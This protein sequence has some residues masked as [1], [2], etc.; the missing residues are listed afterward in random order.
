PPS[1]AAPAR[2]RRKPAVRAARPPP[3]SPESPTDHAATAMRVCSSSEIINRC[4]RL[5]ARQHDSRYLRRAD[6]CGSPNPGLLYAPLTI[7]LA[8]LAGALVFWRSGELGRRAGVA[9]LV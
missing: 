3:E 2:R 8:V 7:M 4:D 1:K 6:H 5:P 9:L